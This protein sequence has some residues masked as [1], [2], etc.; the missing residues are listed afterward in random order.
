MKPKT[1]AAGSRND[2]DKF[3]DDLDDLS[4]HASATRTEV[5]SASGA[6]SSGTAA[7]FL[8]LD[9]FQSKDSR[10]RSRFGTH[11]SATDHQEARPESISTLEKDLGSPLQLG[12][13][14][15]T[16]RRGASG[17]IGAS[18]LIITST[19]VG[20][21]MHWKG[22]K[23]SD[24]LEAE[25]RLV[26]HVNTRFRKNNRMHPI[27]APG[28]S[29]AH[30]VDVTSEYPKQCVNEEEYNSTLLHDRQS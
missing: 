13:P 28:S 25:D 16:A 14:E 22:M 19:P 9:L 6:T 11:N 18:D 5:E 20:R 12:G 4:I 21:F 29:S 8:G 23:P 17:C 1:S 30:T 10:S 15:A 26:A 7:T 2:L 27:Y 3:V 24:L